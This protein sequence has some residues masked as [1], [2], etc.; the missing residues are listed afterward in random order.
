MHDIFYPVISTSPPGT[1]AIVVNRPENGFNRR[2]SRISADTGHHVKRLRLL[3]FWH[4]FIFLHHSIVPHET[5]WRG[6]SLHL[7]FPRS[8]VVF[9]HL[10]SSEAICG[11]TINKPSAKRKSPASVP[12]R[13]RP[14]W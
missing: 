4:G 8:P 11:S 7:L 12:A 13:F 9:T 6:Y 2:L 14:E 1:A 5:N 3:G 10:R